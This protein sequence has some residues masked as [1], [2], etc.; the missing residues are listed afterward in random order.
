MFVLL[1]NRGGIWGGGG[2]ICFAFVFV[3]VWFLVFDAGD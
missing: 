2:V 3:L 1:A